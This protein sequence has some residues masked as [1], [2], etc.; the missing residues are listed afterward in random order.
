MLPVL[1]GIAAGMAACAV[2]MLIGQVIVMLWMR[3]RRRSGVVYEVVEQVEAEEGRVSEEG[4]P[5]YEE[6][7]KYEEVEREEVDEKKELLG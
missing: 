5:K 3:H 4:L 1:V 2:G 6:A 7:P